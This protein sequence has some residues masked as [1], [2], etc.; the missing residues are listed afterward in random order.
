MTKLTVTAQVTVIT[1]DSVV[2]TCLT[3][4]SLKRLHTITA[5]V[6]NQVNT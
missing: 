5:V 6:P 4:R 1:E 2:A 3:S